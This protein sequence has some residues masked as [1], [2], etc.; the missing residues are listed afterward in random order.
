MYQLFALSSVE[1]TYI[2][3]K[4][5]N[6][7]WYSFLQKRE[8]GIIWITEFPTFTLQLSKN[9]GSGDVLKTLLDSFI[10]GYF[11]CNDCSGPRAWE[12]G[13]QSLLVIPKFLSLMT[14]KKSTEIATSAVSF[15]Y[16]FLAPVQMGWLAP[17][18]LILRGTAQT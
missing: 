1:E 16:N 7:Y 4:N 18:E 13:L 14:S 12:G 6:Q 17:G 3:H 8:G 11:D 9:F 10:F 5:Q 2:V 15:K